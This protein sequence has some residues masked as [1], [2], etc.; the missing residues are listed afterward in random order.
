[1]R[2][3]RT[4][5]IAAGLAVLALT[6]RVRADE[7]DGWVLSEDGSHPFDLSIVGHLDSRIIGGG[8]ILGIP[9]APRGFAPTINDAFFVEV[10]LGAGGRPAWAWRPYGYALG[11]VRYELFLFEWMGVFVC[12]RGGVYVP[13][14][15]DVKPFP[16]GYGAV[17]VH[18]MISEDFSFR[19]EGGYGARAGVTFHF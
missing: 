4:A 6:G 7:P 2:T 3:P 10:D 11:G 9:V 19:L 5:W 13:L 18:F 16:A 1:M 17:G 8:V 12:G 14:V 15:P